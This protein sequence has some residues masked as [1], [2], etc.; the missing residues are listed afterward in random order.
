[1][2]RGAARFGAGRLGASRIP[3]LERHELAGGKLAAL[4]SRHASRDLF[5]AHRL[6]TPSEA[7]QLDRSR[8]RLAFVVYGGINRKDW[9]TVSPDDVDFT[10]QELEDQL[11]PVLRVAQAREIQ[12]NP[13]WAPRLVR[14][15]RAALA[16]VLPLIGSGI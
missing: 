13:D 4:L 5:D 16:V 10:Q 6:L 14:E 3:V 1:M 12:R 15:C 8:L 7:A 11:V 2:G 9:R